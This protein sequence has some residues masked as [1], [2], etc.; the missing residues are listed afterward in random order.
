MALTP[1]APGASSDPTAGLPDANTFGKLQ[2]QWNTFLSKPE[3]QAAL[4]SFGINMLQPPSFGDNPLAQAGRAI[5]HAGQTV[6]NIE[7]MDI[8]KQEA[9]SKE[10]LRAAQADKAAMGATIA[11]QGAE[12]AQ[13]RL[14]MQRVQTQIQ[15][16]QMYERRRGDIEAENKA[17]AGDLSNPAPGKPGHR[18]PRPVPSFTEFLAED[19]TARMIAAGAGINVPAG[20]IAAA[21]ASTVIKYDASGKRVP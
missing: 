2:D 14:G 10:D 18:P 9:A 6:G 4:L 8:R 7:Q 17:T 5:G 1:F 15:L 3:G 11:G 16:Q 13:Q 12:L 21:P 20:P 19:P